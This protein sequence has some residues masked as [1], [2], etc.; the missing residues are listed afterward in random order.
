VAASKTLAG[1]GLL[2]RS[3]RGHVKPEA[4]SLASKQNERVFLDLLIGSAPELVGREIIEWESPDFLL[5]GG[6]GA[7][8]VEVTESTLQARAGAGLA[9]EQSALRERVVTLAQRY[10]DEHDV[11]PIRCHRAMQR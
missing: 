7:I 11:R 3:V 4:G 2:R 8:G 6:D 5:R 1:S 9:H 10:Y